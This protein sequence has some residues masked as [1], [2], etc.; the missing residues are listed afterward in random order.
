MSDLSD[1]IALDAL[2]PQSTSADGVT[3]T[4]RSVS[5][6]IAADK[7]ARDLAAQASTNKGPGFRICQIV[8]SGGAR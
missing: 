5:E 6:Q 8:P 2:K 1:Q 4:R 3:I 7:Y